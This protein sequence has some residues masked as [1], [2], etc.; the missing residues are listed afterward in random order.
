M[1]KQIL[2]T[3]CLLIL[4]CF[5]GLNLFA[6]NP[7]VENIGI[8]LRNDQCG[9]AISGNGQLFVD[10]S[11][12]ANAYAT[13]QNYEYEIK[14]LV[15]GQAVVISKPS[16]TL[17]NGNFLFLSELWSQNTTHFVK[18]NNGYS[19]RIKAQKNGA[20]GEYGTKCTFYVRPLVV[21]NTNSQNPNKTLAPEG[22]NV[23]WY[24]QFLNAYACPYNN[25]SS[26]NPLVGSANI[27]WRITKII[28]NSNI[29]PTIATLNNA[30]G[31]FL[32][33]KVVNNTYP[34]DPLYNLN[35]NLPVGFITNGAN[36]C[37]ELAMVYPD[38]TIGDF[39]NGSS[40]YKYVGQS[41]TAR[42]NDQ[43]QLNSSFDAVISPN[44]SKDNFSLNLKTE[45]KS[46][47]QVDVYDITGK[48]IEKNIYDLDTL[49]NLNIGDKYQ[50]GIY[51]I[52]I[53]QDENTKTVKL[54]KE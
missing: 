15:T 8:H 29:L 13:I 28:P 16:S 35:T 48:I 46:L 4:T 32:L 12:S 14:D 5:T 42:S 9:N 18:T 23:G 38:G 53:T 19:I 45:S 54:I 36:Y 51:N 43:I 37:F 22:G 2:K 50:S 52:I 30:N 24:A 6:Q 41:T 1:K 39:N 3:L 25:I 34:G 10:M 7:V 44:P 49:S 33:C 40:C 27:Q 17:T 31:Q 21:Y 20:W 26:Y 47:V 11:N